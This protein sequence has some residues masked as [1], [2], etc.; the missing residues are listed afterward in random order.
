MTERTT[1]E[2]NATRAGIRD[3]LAGELTTEQVIEGLNELYVRSNPNWRGKDAAVFN[4]AITMLKAT[5]PE[6]EYYVGWKGYMSGGARAEIHAE[7]NGLFFGLI[8]Y[9]DGDL[10]S[11]DWDAGGTFFKGGKKSSCD[12]IPNESKE[13]T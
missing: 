6:P 1:E 4:D 8:E 12:L 7:R 9:N 11:A 3:A 13:P 5:L 2:R 10:T